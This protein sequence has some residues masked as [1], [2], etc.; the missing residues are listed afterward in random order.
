[1]SFLNNTSYLYN[2]ICE[3]PYGIS[4]EYN[5]V[6]IKLKG[7]NINAQTIKKLL[8]NI[9]YM[10]RVC[11][12]TILVFQIAALNFLD[13]ATLNVFE[14]IM[15][16]LLKNGIKRIKLNIKSIDEKA[17]TYQ[18]YANSLIFECRV[19][20]NKYIINNK[21]ISLFEQKKSITLN[22][23]RAILRNDEQKDSLSKVY[24]DIPAFLKPQSID[25]ELSDNISEIISEIADNALEHSDGDCLI[26]LKV[27]NVYGGNNRSYKLINIVVLDLSNTK[28]YTSLRKNIETGNLTGNNK[29]VVDA[30][31]YHKKFFDDSYDINLFAFLSIF[32]RYVTTRKDSDNSGGTGLTTLIRYLIGRTYKNNC[33]VKSGNYSFMF[34][35]KN[36]RIN[37]DGTIGFNDTNNYHMDIPNKMY[38][39]NSSDSD[40]NGVNYNGT[41]YNLT[42][43]LKGE[44]V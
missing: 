26:N 6:V 42:L 15:Y 17:Y 19:S 43:I 21:Y 13:D 18:Y 39:N 30:Y 20:N 14:I 36:L 11:N 4:I 28:I 25:L 44:D 31:N 27:F 29:I 10:R 32:Q 33:Y 7:K 34:S 3:N 37:D 1:M 2:D 38:Y 41:I 9:K 23:Y 22:N 24:S 35:E 16:D 12:Y 8:G 5:S 40:H